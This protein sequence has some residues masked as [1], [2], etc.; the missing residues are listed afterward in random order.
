MPPETT[1]KLTEREWLDM[2]V[3]YLGFRGVIPEEEA[4]AIRDA[5]RPEEAIRRKLKEGRR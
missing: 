4:Q 2:R 3:K 5:A 1:R